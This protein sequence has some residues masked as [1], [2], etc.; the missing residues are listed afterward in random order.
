MRRLALLLL[1]PLAAAAEPATLIRASDLK[2]A[3]ATDAPTLASLPENA[4][5]EALERKGGWTRVRAAD[6]E[7]WVRMLALRFASSGNA[8]QGDSGI[9]QVVNVAR[10]GTSGT[11]VTTGVRGLDAEQLANARPNPAELA[12]MESLATDRA[13]AEAFAAQG[14]L[15]PARV[16]YPKP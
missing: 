7:G 12:K 14:K 16:E 11:Q 9:A 8:K 10:T 3:P 13:G 2:E 15:A 6:G 5:V 4:A 1:L